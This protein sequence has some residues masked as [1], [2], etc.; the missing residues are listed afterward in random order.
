VHVVGPGE[1]TAPPQ[2]IPDA[3]ALEQRGGNREPG[4]GEPRERGQDEDPDE[5]A[6]RQEDDDADRE[7][8]KE[9]PARGPHPGREHT[10]PDVGESKERSTED[11]QRR[12][13]LRPL[14]DRELV[15]RG[16]DRPEPERGKEPAPVEPNRLGHELADRPVR[17]RELCDR[18]HGR[19]RYPVR[20]CKPDPNEGLTERR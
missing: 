4:E 19:R 9:R 8:G 13:E 3:A 1:A 11:E 16:N 18:G 20:D 10:A 12:L 6:D 15:E 14:A 2:R 5:H 7:G 17:G